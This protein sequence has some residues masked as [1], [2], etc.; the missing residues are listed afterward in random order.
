MKR[1]FFY[2]IEGFQSPKEQ[3]QLGGFGFIVYLDKELAKGA[4]DRTLPEKSPMMEI[5]REI[6]KNYGFS[7]AELKFFEPYLFARNENNNISCLVQSFNVPGNACGLDADWQQI[8]DL[9][10]RYDRGNFIGYYPHNVDYAQQASALLSLF[11]Q[12]ANTMASVLGIDVT[13]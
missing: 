7:D 2:H 3:N 8:D 11:T 6:I 10:K 13:E 4:F 12:W 5:G 9:K 1:R